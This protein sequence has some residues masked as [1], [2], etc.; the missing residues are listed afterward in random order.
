[1][2]Y[3]FL[4]ERDA[5]LRRLASDVG[6]ISLDLISDITD[7]PAVAFVLGAVVL[8]KYQ[9][10]MRQTR[11]KN[12]LIRARDNRNIAPINPVIV[13]EIEHISSSKF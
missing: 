4:M 9:I 13:K 7:I 3:S 5:S 1:M 6:N 12:T 11:I 2:V 10:E 8:A